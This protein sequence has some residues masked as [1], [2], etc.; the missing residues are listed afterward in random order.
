ME[1]TL[2]FN[3]QNCCQEDIDFC[4][5][6][7]YQHNFSKEMRGKIEHHN[8]AFISDDENDVLSYCIRLAWK[9]AMFYERMHKTAYN[10]KKDH[11]SEIIKVIRY[12]FSDIS[13][14]DF[15]DFDTWHESVCN[16]TDYHMTVGIWQKLINM[17]FKYVYCIRKYYQA[18]LGNFQFDQCHMPLDSNILRFF[19]YPD[20][21]NQLTYQRYSDIQKD[22]MRELAQGSKIKSRI[23]GDFII[24]EKYKVNETASNIK[25]SLDVLKDSEMKFL[26][27]SKTWDELK[28]TMDLENWI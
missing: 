26:I 10:E 24:W 4:I 9:D 7:F 28:K 5:N 22:I 23:E 13:N 15:K 17:T 20:K 27:E 11:K 6:S 3:M 2:L 16:S 12:Y 14:G 1:H 18:E 21:W 8:I 19:E 25:D